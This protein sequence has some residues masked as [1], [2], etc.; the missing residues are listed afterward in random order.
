M[1]T[2]LSENPFA[3]AIT[4]ETTIVVY[5]KKALKQNSKAKRLV[6]NKHYILNAPKG[7]SP[8]KVQN[9]SGNH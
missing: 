2:K 6:P 1:N 7:S 4:F 3:P 9:Y 8:E 5:F